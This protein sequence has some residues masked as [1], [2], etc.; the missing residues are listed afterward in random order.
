VSDESIANLIYKRGFLR[1]AKK[2][3]PLDNNEIIETHFSQYNIICLQDII[4][5]IKTKG[6][7]AVRMINALW[8]LF[9]LFNFLG[10]FI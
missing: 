8:Y 7:Y 10:L 4:H 3:V 2:R 5:E 9:M 6:P 1:D